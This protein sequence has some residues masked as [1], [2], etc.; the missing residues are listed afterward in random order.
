MYI[1]KK[2][3]VVLIVAAIALLSPSVHAASNITIYASPAVSSAAADLVSDFINVTNDI[4]ATGRG[5]NVSLKI[6]SDADAHAA[7]IAGAGP[8]LYLSQSTTLPTDIITQGLSLDGQLIKFAKDSL[9][10]Y[11]SAAKVA[12]LKSV[13]TGAT[14]DNSKLLLSS[15]TVSIPDPALN[16]PYGISAQKLLGGTASG[17]VYSRLDKKGLLVKEIDSVSAY[18]DVEYIDKVDLSLIHI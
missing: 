9:V 18:G 8:D 10:I 16:D 14:V 11:S 1:K 6:M 5:Y 13:L 2:R 7:I 4:G 15:L 17:S 3:Y 12:A